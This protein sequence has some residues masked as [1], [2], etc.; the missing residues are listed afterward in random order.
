[1]DREVG[2]AVQRQFDGTYAFR[3]GACRSWQV[4]A[5]S[6]PETRPRVL[7]H[8]GVGEGF[9]ESRLMSNVVQFPSSVDPEPQTGPVKL[10]LG[11]NQ[12]PQ[13][14]YINVD[15]EQYAGVDVV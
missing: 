3:A 10:Y 5:T 6:L 9:A 4:P 1:M 12:N 13:P 8:R 2:R 7:R 14:G 11:C 15:I